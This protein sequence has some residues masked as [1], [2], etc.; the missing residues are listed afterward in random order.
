M[1][2]PTR[3]RPAVSAAASVAVLTVL[4]LALWQPAQA[5][6]PDP[7]AATSTTAAPTGPDDL[8][9][10][11]RQLFDTGC[12]SCHGEGGVGTADGPTLVGVGEAA[13][14]FMLRTGRMPLAEPQGQSPSKPPA[15]TDQEIQALV[16]YVGSLG[17][18]PAIPQVDVA[19]GDLVEGGELFRANCA[20][21]HGAAAV[22]GA[23]SYG[24]Y[25][26]SLH[27]VAEVQIAEAVRVGPGQMPVFDEDV[28]TD[29]ELNSLVAYVRY[30]QDP[31]DP[32]GFSLGRVGPVA[33]GYVIWV[34]GASAVVVFIRWITRRRAD[35]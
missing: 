13:A 5:Q 9:A 6:S 23:L 3:R 34:V 25:A 32:G 16:A 20:A 35:G 12:V 30:L 21:C 14:D 8:V 29:D 2:A 18:G 27:S 17:P 28:F 4:G 7:T 24:D 15:Y 26:P 10:I 33:E 19:A 1:S 11:G 22:G 31:A